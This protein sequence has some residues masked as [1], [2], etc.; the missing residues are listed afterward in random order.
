MLDA[1][2]GALIRRRVDLDKRHLT[3]ERVSLQAYVRMLITEFQ[4]RP[5]RADWEAR[6]T[7]PDAH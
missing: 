2:V 7:E 1:E 6:L 5:L 3:T 4:I